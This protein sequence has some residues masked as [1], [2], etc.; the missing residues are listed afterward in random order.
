[1][2]EELES[3]LMICDLYFC[4]FDHST[5]TTDEMQIENNLTS[6]L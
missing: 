2:L 6:N 5:D 1:M 4:A 3:V